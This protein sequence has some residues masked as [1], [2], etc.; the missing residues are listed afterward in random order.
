MRLKDLPALVLSLASLLTAA[1]GFVK[2]I[3]SEA[4]QDENAIHTAVQ[5]GQEDL[6]LRAR[7]EDLERIVKKAPAVGP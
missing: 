2:E 3:R 1:A 6:A 4:R 7:I 5:E